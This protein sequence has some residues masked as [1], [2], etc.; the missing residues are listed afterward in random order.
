MAENFTRG[1]PQ[2]TWSTTNRPGSRRTHKHSARTPC[3]TAA[4]SAS[5]RTNRPAAEPG[6][7]PYRLTL[8][9]LVPS[10][11]ACGAIGARR[12]PGW[13]PCLGPGGQRSGLCSRVHAV[14]SVVWVAGSGLGV[15]QMNTG[16]RLVTSRSGPPET[17]CPEASHNLLWGLQRSLEGP[18]VQLGVLM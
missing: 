12:K 5:S 11:R 18:M 6:H 9:V 7:T 14:T 17:L 15:C 16:R 10:S 13:T 2:Y 1:S 3:G 4:T 8:S